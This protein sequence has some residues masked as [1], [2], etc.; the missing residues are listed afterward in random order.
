MPKISFAAILRYIPACQ[1]WRLMDIDGKDTTQEF[2]LQTCAFMNTKIAPALS[3]DKDNPVM[4]TIHIKDNGWL[5]IVKAFKKAN[6]MPL[7]IV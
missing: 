6:S 3:K 5:R 4:I 2:R 1:E 7:E